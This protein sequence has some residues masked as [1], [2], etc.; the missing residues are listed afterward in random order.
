MMIGD[1]CSFFPERRPRRRRTDL[2]SQYYLFLFTAT[3]PFF[4]VVFI[5]GVCVSHALGGTIQRQ[6]AFLVIRHEL[7]YEVSF[8]DSLCCL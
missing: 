7:V 5:F 4:P 8:F 3:T 1:G 2:R 6:R